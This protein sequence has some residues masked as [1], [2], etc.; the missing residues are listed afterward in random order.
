M[1][2]GY[3]AA[4]FISISSLNLEDCSRSP[5]AEVAVAGRASDMGGGRGWWRGGRE[6]ESWHE[7]VLSGLVEVE[8]EAEASAVALGFSHLM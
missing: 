2:E 8:A 3:S 1:E 7:P 5:S 4:M 6:A